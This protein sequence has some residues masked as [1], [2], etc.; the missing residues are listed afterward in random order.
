MDG[1]RRY[2][3]ADLTHSDR[4][5]VTRG[6]RVE[7]DPTLTGGMHGRD[8]GARRGVRLDF[9]Q[10]SQAEVRRAADRAR[11]RSRS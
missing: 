5:E 7:R 9:R 2:G 6:G 4:V 8:A 3:L 1:D 10:P 11:G